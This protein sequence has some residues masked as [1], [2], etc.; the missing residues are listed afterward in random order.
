VEIIQRQDLIGQKV[1]VES[2]EG[3]WALKVRTVE[4][5]FL[6]HPS[7][8]FRDFLWNEMEALTQR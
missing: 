6:L 1:L 4:L 8:H 2:E 3:M 7:T 5:S